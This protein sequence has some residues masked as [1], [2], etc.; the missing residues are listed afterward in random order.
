MEPA[1]DEFDN[2][3]SNSVKLPVEDSV[4]D[5]DF[6][7][8]REASPNDDPRLEMQ[9]LARPET[10][11]LPRNFTALSEEFIQPHDDGSEPVRH[12]RASNPITNFEMYMAMWCEKYSILG[13]A[14]T[15]LLEGYKLV[16]SMENLMNLPKDVRTLKKRLVS[17][18]PLISQ[19][20]KLIDVNQEKLPTMSPAERSQ[21]AQ[22]RRANMH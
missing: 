12:K 10:E 22:K 3:N 19:R 14:Y 1:D 8:I 17:Q 18:L 7:P 15:G 21:A 9:P 2:P 13:D 4:P 20:H 6:L 16:E 5:E 11:T